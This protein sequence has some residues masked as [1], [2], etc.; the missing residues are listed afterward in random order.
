MDD[1]YLRSLGLPVK[2]RSDDIELIIQEGGLLARWRALS[3]H[4][5]D[6]VRLSLALGVLSV[7]LGLSG[8]LLAIGLSIGHGGVTGISA[9]L[10]AT[11]IGLALHVAMSKHVGA[12]P[13]DSTT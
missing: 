13:K 4:P 5:D 2:K 6:V 7:T 3:S 10:F 1:C 12:R 11:G 8:A 9:V